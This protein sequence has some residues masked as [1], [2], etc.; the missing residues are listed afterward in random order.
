VVRGVDLFGQPFEERTA[1]LAF[2]L[3]GCRYSSRHHLPPGSWITLEVAQGTERSN[4]RA[5]VSSIERRH[6]TRE[7]FH[8]AVV[9]ENPRNIWG[10][11]RPPST[12]S[13]LAGSLQ[14]FPSE[15]NEHDRGLSESGTVPSALATPLD[16]IVGPTT[17]RPAD[18]ASAEESAESPAQN[19]N[20]LLLGELSAKLERQARHALEAATAEATEQI[21]RIVEELEQK[22]L[23]TAEASIQQWR[24]EFDEARTGARENFLAELASRQ[25][26]L[27]R[28]LQR[29]FETALG[30]AREL[31]G[32]LDRKSEILRAE[33][34]AALR[35]A[36]RTGQA[37]LPTEA[38]DRARPVERGSDH[39]S[40]EQAA[41]ESPAETGRERR[42]SEMG[43][44][45]TPENE[46]LKSSLDASV[47]PLAARLSERSI[48]IQGSGPQVS[49]SLAEI[50]QPLAQLFAEA[51]DTLSNV[52]SAF[53]QEVTRARASLSEI[54]HSANR[55]RDYAS[56]L[57]AAS[58]DTLNELDRRIKNLLRAQTEEMS[59]RVESL[60]AGVPERLTAVVNSLARRLVEQAATEFESK[61]QPHFKRVP[62]L[63]AE[64]S[65][66]E[67]HIEQGLRLHREHLRQVAEN[68]QRDVA[69]ELRATVSALHSDFELARGEALA[70]WNQELDA[71]GVRASHAAA[72]SIGGASE[73]FEQEA[74]T[75]LRVQVEQTL[76]TAALAFEEKTAEACRNFALQLE[77]R[78][79]AH[80]AQVGHELDQSASELAGRARTQLEETA[81]AAAASFGQILRGISEQEVRQFT[82]TSR[83]VLE[84]RI[85]DLDRAS[86]E[87]AS[88]VEASAGTSIVRF[89]EQ[90]A[91]QL[92]ASATEGQDVLAAEYSS[93]LDRYRAERDV[94]EKQWVDNLELLSNKATD[95]HQERLETSSDSWMV[96]SV[97]RL[98]EQGKN[99]IE[100][101]VRSADQAL[102]DSCSKVFEGFAEML[103]GRTPEAARAPFTP[104]PS[105]E[106]SKTPEPH[107]QAGA[108]RA[109]G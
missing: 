19:Q 11:D 36:G 35:M 62:E 56:Q 37:G 57:E 45:Q 65:S 87:F 61:F 14:S 107:N 102:R 16:W 2:N 58:H 75:R 44:A 100:S 12:W 108:Y 64:L 13:I 9:L 94:R 74:R 40:D 15:L 67:V 97:R 93:T 72:E 89:R 10:L 27:L 49:D 24:E 78:S 28:G 4:V 25:Q 55:M 1:T 73:W 31:M 41:T 92:D 34:G 18:A 43:L 101:L 103:R 38:A 85:E 17:G 99:A 82:S 59:R 8:V 52:R 32:E 47:Q 26:E 68:Y 60:T 33:G 5:C 29:E 96:S 51:R 42:E 53:E 21:R 20:P 54:R 106:I 95:K 104:E 84:D 79:T 105:R 3:H 48:D 86:G 91:A 66:Q 6:P 83:S 80:L 109:N 90:M 22:R 39:S 81:K 98:N 23:A 69:S 7:C 70:K 50:R 76:A 77:G 46:P 30:P 71:A 88:K 63:L